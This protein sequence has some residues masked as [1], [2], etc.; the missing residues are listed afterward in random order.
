MAKITTEKARKLLDSSTGYA[1]IQ[2]SVQPGGTSS[3]PVIRTRAGT[4][5]ELSP[6]QADTLINECQYR[7]VAHSVLIGGDISHMDAVIENTATMIYWSVCTLFGPTAED[8]HLDRQI[9]IP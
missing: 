6:E 3:A 2:A 7:Y 4:E 5:Y 1:W 8:L 9:Q